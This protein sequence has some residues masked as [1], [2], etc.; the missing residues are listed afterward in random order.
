MKP[1]LLVELLVDGSAPEK[2]P[3]RHQHAMMQA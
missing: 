2:G 1:Q 3:K